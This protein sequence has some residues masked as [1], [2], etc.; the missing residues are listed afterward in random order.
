M[1]LTEIFKI[2]VS[3]SNGYDFSFTFVEPQGPEKV[4]CS[5]HG[6]TTLLPFDHH[7]SQCKM[8]ALSHSVMKTRLRESSAPLSCHRCT[9]VRRAEHGTLDIGD[10]SNELP[11]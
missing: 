5:I 3:W 9:E 11:N 4:P 1:L 6:E 2:L 10:M 7:V 8:N